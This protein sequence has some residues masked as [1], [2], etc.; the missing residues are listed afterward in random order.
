MHILT[1][2]ECNINM[3]PYSEETALAYA[4]GFAYLFRLA[5]QYYI[6]TITVMDS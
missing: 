1:V 3:V 2:V 5:K 6:I 4:T